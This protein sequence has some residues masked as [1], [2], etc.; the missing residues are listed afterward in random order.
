MDKLSKINLGFSSSNIVESI[1]EK[2]PIG[3]KLIL[4]KTVTKTNK[5]IQ[6]SYLKSK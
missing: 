2:M 6:K 4:K 5:R 1:K 3:D